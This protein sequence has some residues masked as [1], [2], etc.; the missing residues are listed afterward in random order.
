MEMLEMKSSLKQSRKHHQ[1]SR[2]VE[3]NKSN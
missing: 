2:K 1:Q 3:E